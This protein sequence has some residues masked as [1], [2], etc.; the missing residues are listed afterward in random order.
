M[1]SSPA[2]PSRLATAPTIAREALIEDGWVHEPGQFDSITASTVFL[3][4][5]E[6]PPELAE[7]T[8]KCAAAIRGAQIHELG[9]RDHFAYKTHPAEVAAIIRGF[10]GGP[11]GVQ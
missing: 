11:T 8:R 7:V 2:W 4:G 3:A 5:T 10:A 6:S 1:K 9:G